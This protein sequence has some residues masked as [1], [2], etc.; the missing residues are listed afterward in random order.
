LQNPG[1]KP[2]RVVGASVN[3]GIGICPNIKSDLPSYLHPGETGTVDFDCKIV[4]A[5]GFH[6]SFPLYYDC[7]GRLRETELRISSL[8]AT[9]ENDPH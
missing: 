5:T 4:T 8:D 1:G 7:D 3:C 2:I 6:V 9:E